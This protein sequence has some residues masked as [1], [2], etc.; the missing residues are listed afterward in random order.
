[1]NSVYRL[2]CLVSAA[3]AALSFESIAH[4]WMAPKEAAQLTNPLVSNE[5]IIVSGKE[6]YQEN[7]G[8]CH[9]DA[10]EGLTAEQAGLTKAPPNLKVRFKN[11]SVGDLFWKIQKGRG[12]MPSFK[13][14]LSEDEIWTILHYIGSKAD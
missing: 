1:M 3:I 4:E 2:I 13:D 11:H 9:G 7:C 14:D 12:D 5:A 6:L 8:Y 10:L